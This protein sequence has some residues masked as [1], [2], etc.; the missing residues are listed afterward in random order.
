[1]FEVAHGGSAVL[2]LHRNA[3][4]PERAELGP[5]VHRERIV[6]VDLR[7]ARRD[8]MGSEHLHL[9][10]Q[11]VGGLAQREIQAR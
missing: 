2:L 6:A 7:G 9:G 3:E 8:L 10:T 4:H 5:Q 1:M 11:H